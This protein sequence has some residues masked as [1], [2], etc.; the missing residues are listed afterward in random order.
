MRMGLQEPMWSLWEF[1][2]WNSGYSPCSR[3]YCWPLKSGLGVGKKNRTM[4]LLLLS[5]ALALLFTTDGQF[6]KCMTMSD[7]NM[8]KMNSY[9]SIKCCADDLCN[10]F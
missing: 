2:R 8:L 1:Q 10:T 5:L 7:C 4:K 3:M 6:Q 9:I